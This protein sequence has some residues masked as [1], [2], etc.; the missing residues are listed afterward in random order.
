MSKGSGLRGGA[1][2]LERIQE[3]WQYRWTP[4]TESALSSTRL[5][6]S[7][8]EEAAAARLVERF[9]ETASQAGSAARMPRALVMS[10]VRGW[11]C[12]AEAPNCLART[13]PVMPRIHRSERGP[14]PRAMERLIVLQHAREPL[15]SASL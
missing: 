4:D 15:R 5:Y 8:D 7:H 1:R 9:E 12:F 2:D 10:G 3:V 13:A 14:C 6:G 11:G